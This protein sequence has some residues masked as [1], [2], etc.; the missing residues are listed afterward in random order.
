MPARPQSPRGRRFLRH[1]LFAAGL[2][3]LLS[4][5]GTP[6]GDFGEVRPLLSSDTTHDWLGPAATA[7]AGVAPSL[8]ELTDDERQ[9]RDLAF[10]L[11]EPPYDRQRWDSVLREYGAVGDYRRGAFDRTA[12]A[13]RLLS[14]RY[15]SPASRYAQLT[16]DIRNDITR[17]PQFFETASRVVDVDNKRRKSLAFISELSPYE[18]A[19][20]MRRIRENALVIAWVRDS[21]TQRATSY[22]FALE[23]LVI[24]TPSGEAAQVELTLNQLQAANDRY[25]DGLP[26]PNPRFVAT[27]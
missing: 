6:N 21:L 15:R 18:R 19:N 2:L 14:E 26:P 4:G 24:M 27:Y 11:I 16:D 25:R 8:F 13:A 22:R 5:C 3:S 1:S 9:L 17:M 12:Y 20:A 23:R 10:P 7:R